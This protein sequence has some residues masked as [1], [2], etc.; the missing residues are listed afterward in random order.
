MKIRDTGGPDPA[1]VMIHGWGQTSEAMAPLARLL[2][3]RL[4]VI[5]FDLPGH[6][7]AR[8]E[9]GPYTFR[10]YVETLG[11]VVRALNGAPFYLLGWSMGGTIAA[12]YALEK[13]APAP[14]GLILLSATPRFVAQGRNPGMGQHP[15][16]VKK[17]KRMIRADHDAGLRDFV[18]RFFDSGE[19]ISAEDRRRVEKALIPP[20]FPPAGETLLETLDE[21]AAADLTATP[22]GGLEGRVLLIYGGLD[23]ICPPGG[24]RLWRKVFDGGPAAEIAMEGAGHAP[25]LTKG[26]EVAS[27][28]EE[29]VLNSGQVLSSSWQDRE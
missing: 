7:E 5:T 26:A 14:E 13:K 10:R 3:K 17:M 22:G 1:V 18:G 2:E 20:L 25:H 11:G 28:V 23:R 12:M 15:A 4:R 8:D 21:L 16:A 29:F 27:A 9:A 19:K 24:Q 6:G